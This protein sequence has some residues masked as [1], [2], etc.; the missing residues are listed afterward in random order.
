MET[1]ASGPPAATAAQPPRRS[2][3]HPAA[4]V[5]TVLPVALAVLAGGGAGSG[6]G[7][8][9]TCGIHCGTERWAVKTLSD[10]AAPQVV[11]SP[12]PMSVSKMV[13]ITAPNSSPDESRDKA[14]MQAVTVTAQLV[15]YKQELS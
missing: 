1:Q 14:E 4:A 2:R 13:A 10:A 15:G 5:A 11:L 9:A 7:L 3:V 8:G 12:Q 6:G